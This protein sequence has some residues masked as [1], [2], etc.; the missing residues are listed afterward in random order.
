MQVSTFD[1]PGK[2]RS[3]P[4]LAASRK[5]W[6]I[7]NNSN[8]R[9]Y[10]TLGAPVAEWEAYY[11]RR[12][13]RL[14]LGQGQGQTHID[15]S[16]GAQPRGGEWRS[17][18]APRR[19]R[20]AVERGGVDG[21]ASGRPEGHIGLAASRT[22]GRVARHVSETQIWDSFAALTTVF[23]VTCILCY[24]KSCA[25]SLSLLPAQARA[26]VEV[27][28]AQTANDQL[29]L[30]STEPKFSKNIQANAFFVRTLLA[31]PGVQSILVL[32]E[33]FFP[34]GTLASLDTNA[35]KDFVRSD[36]EWHILRLGYHP[37]FD[38][39]WAATDSNAPCPR[40]CVCERSSRSPQVCKITRSWQKQ[41]TR[42]YCDMR[43][44]VAA[45]FHSRSLEFVSSLAFAAM[46]G[47]ASHDK[48]GVPMVVDRWWPGTLLVAHYLTP[49]GIVQNHTEK[50]PTRGV[51]NKRTLHALKMEHFGRV[52]VV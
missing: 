42:D 47:W 31:R 17:V 37:V 14:P 25:T 52:C 49:G 36:P 22:T 51:T 40:A 11:E 48:R 26:A 13:L 9:L 45:A 19:E 1:R 44:A 4:S 30:K 28:D 2:Y 15:V 12:D 3:E 33:D 23:D 6:R 34:L 8:A 18:R 29:E 7:Y 38:S 16:G 50:S 27:C 35:L 10:A 24:N 46:Q 39:P 43:S 5:L 20:V 41:H 21:R 32:E